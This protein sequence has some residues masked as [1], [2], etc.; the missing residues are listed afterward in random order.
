MSNPLRDRLVPANK[1]SGLHRENH[2]V[3]GSSVIIGEDGKYHMFSSSWL[4][5]QAASWYTDSTIVHSVSDTPEGPYEFLS[6]AIPPRGEGYWDAIMTHNPTIVKYP[7]GYAIFYLGTSGRPTGDIKVDNMT[8]FN[9]KR[10]GVATSKSLD[11]PWERYDKPILEPREE[12][13]WDCCMTSNPAPYVKEDG[14][15]IMIYKSCDMFPDLH[16]KDIRTHLHGVATAPSVLGPYTPQG[17]YL[18]KDYPVPFRTEDCHIWFEDGKYQMLAKVFA[19]G[20]EIFEGG[21]GGYH[22]TS[23]DG[24]NWVMDEEPLI[25]TRTLEWD[26]GTTTTFDRR[27]RVSVL[28]DKDGKATHLF[29]AVREHEEGKHSRNV[30][31]PLKPAE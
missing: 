23:E 19:D 28:K 9:N 7:D 11:G 22:A 31:V 15:V 3:W 1:N 2:T 14:S 4:V 30:C 20:Q 29:F 13:H 8:Y 21:G 18:F 5:N 26:D 27:E 25:Y 17:D 16:T 24:I 10:I 12:G 6:V